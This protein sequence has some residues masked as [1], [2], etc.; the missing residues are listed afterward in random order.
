MCGKK[1]DKKE[2]KKHFKNC[3]KFL[4]KFKDFDFKISELIKKYY[5]IKNASII[6]FLLQRYI[7]LIEHKIRK[8]QEDNNNNIRKIQIYEKKYKNFELKKINPF[9]VISKDIN[10]KNDNYNINNNNFNKLISYNPENSLNIKCSVKPKKFKNNNIIKEYI[11][12]IKQKNKRN[13][14]IICNE[15]NF[16]LINNKALNKSSRLL[17]FIGGCENEIVLNIRKIN[18][19]CIPYLSYLGSYYKGEENIVLEYCKEL[20]KINEGIIN[21]DFVKSISLFCKDLFLGEW[22]IIIINID[23][24]DIFFDLSSLKFKDKSII[25]FLDNKKFYIIGY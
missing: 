8:S 7:K 22:L 10:I 12:K 13:Y 18:K 5:K 1:Y 6:Q 25:F 19:N 9:Y 23:Y 4:E 16:K 21:K 14:F 3:H 11:N 20:Y 15:I 24:M 17:S 2:F